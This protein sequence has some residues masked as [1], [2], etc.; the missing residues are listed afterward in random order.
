MLVAPLRVD[1]LQNL[2]HPSPMETDLTGDRP[3]AQTFGAEGEN[4][5]EKLGL[6]RI[7]VI[8]ERRCGWGNKEAVFMPS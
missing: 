3:V 4:Y 8:G 6:I 7:S 1:C 2:P 5:F